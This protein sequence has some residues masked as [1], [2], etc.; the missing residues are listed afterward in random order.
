MNSRLGKSKFNS[1][2]IILDYG[3]S[4]YIILV[5]HTQKSQNKPPSQSIVVHKEVTLTP[6]IPIK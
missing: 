4:S 5:K 6:I 3:V 1:L 2:K